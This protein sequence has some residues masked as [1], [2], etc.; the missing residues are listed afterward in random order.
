VGNK[1]QNKIF[2]VSLAVFIITFIWLIASFINIGGIDIK[3]EVNFSVLQVA[4]KTTEID[5]PITAKNVR[6]VVWHIGI[7]LYLNLVSVCFL[8][9]YIKPRRPE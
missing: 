9:H 2:W 5:V 3:A 8:V 4:V 1:R 6:N 7:P